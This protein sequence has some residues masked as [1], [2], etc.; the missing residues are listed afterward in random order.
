[1]TKVFSID[2]DGCLYNSLVER[3]LFS[4]FYGLKCAEDPVNYLAYP[5]YELHDS[6]ALLDLFIKKGWFGGDGL[7]AT[8]AADLQQMPTLQHEK[9]TFVDELMNQVCNI[10]I[11]HNL[12]LIGQIDEGS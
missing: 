5:K 3:E 11:K 2:F 10:V 4:F 6:P 12:T 9:A 7:L 8:I 1:M